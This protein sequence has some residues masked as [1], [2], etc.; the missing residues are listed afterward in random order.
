MLWLRL[1]FLY[2]NL[3]RI[4]IHMMG[5][6][7]KAK[8]QLLTELME[9]FQQKAGESIKGKFP[10]SEDEKEEEEDGEEAEVVV[11]ESPM[12]GGMKVEVSGDSPE[13]E[14]GMAE[15]VESK[16]EEPSE[17][18]RGFDIEKMKA[19]IAAKKRR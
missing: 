7:A 3:Q 5:S 1:G 13:G 19:M 9:F 2:F 14:E 12:G 11:E 15:M 6:E 16:L 17:S 18:T 4:R 8:E 10:G